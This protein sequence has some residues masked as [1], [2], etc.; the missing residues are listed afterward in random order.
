MTTNTSQPDSARVD[1][2]P[3]S[4]TRADIHTD[5]RF[6]W[7]TQPV[8][9]I[10]QR[11]RAAAQQRQQ[12]L[13][14]PPGSLGRLEDI[15]LDFAGWQGKATPELKRCSVRIFAADHGV[16]AEG[17]SAFP[18][19]VTV[20]MIR[21]FASGGAAISVLS[22]QLDAD[23]QVLNLG[24][25]APLP[26]EIQQ[27]PAVL[28][29][30]LAPGTGNICET[31]AMTAPQLAAALQAGAE[32]VNSGSAQ[33]FIGGE[34]GIGN[35]TA[36][37]ALT[38]CLLD[39]NAEDSVGRGTGVDDSGLQRKCVVVARALSLH[40]HHC[41]GPL[42][43]LRCL[44]GLEIAA[45]TGAYIAAAQRGV[46][47]LVDGY[48][49]TVAALLACRLNPG[50]RQWLL[51]G[52]RSLE[53]GHTLLLQALAA[54]PLLDLRMRLGE[55]SGAAVAVPLLQNACRLHGEM[56]TFAEAGVSVADD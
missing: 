35:T 51:F 27:H 21:N 19:A 38:A 3:G 44:G 23:F 16:V 33:L 7:L 49:C 31:A 50:V 26:A 37:A 47:V 54:E 1:I 22:R 42:E 25:A 11:A 55:G 41:S 4:D 15:A 28:D 53:P 24:T 32:S 14:K 34:M 9:A 17:V 18:Q 13:T 48:I 10:D 56:A 20:E 2:E 39:V 36:S 45:L 46:P 52:H 30:Q 40:R 8:A 29:L 12:Q 43:T 6:N 5:A